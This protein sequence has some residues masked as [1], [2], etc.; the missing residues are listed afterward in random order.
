MAA[1]Q[2]TIRP[3]DVISSD[4]INRIIG[5]LNEHDAALAGKGSTG[6]AGVLLTGFAPAAEQNVGKQ[7]TVYGNFDFPLS[8][9]AL[10][11]DGLPI[12][13]GAFLPG[14]NNLQLVFKLPNTIAVPVGGRKSVV[15]RIVNSKGS[16]QRGYTLLPEVPGLPDPVINTAQD[17]AT[18]SNTLRSS[19]EA[20]ISGLNFAAPAGNNVVTLTLNPGPAQTVFNLVP[21]AGSL[22]QP[23]PQ[24][25]TLLVDMPALVDAN[26]IAI[27]DSAPALLSVTVPG[28]S[29][30][31]QIGA[32]IERIS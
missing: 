30:P 10:T 13:P 7:L 8:T 17:V 29:T 22:I 24:V 27:G 19:S 28:A 16:D 4:L 2:D 25:S 14:S 1:I 32:A 26:G 11:I 31:A 12:T 23:A 3:G 21:K 5:L 6:G 9:N 15:V 18:A 20:R